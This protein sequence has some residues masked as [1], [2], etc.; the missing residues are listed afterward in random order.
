MLLIH[1]PMLAIL[2]FAFNGREHSARSTE[3]GIFGDFGENLEL[4]VDAAIRGGLP[5]WQRKRA[6]G[7]HFS[8]KGIPP[9]HFS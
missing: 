1:I 7:R 8:D 4:L 2:S 5:Y 6:G 3:G 9:P